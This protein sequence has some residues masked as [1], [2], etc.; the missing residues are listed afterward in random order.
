MSDVPL[1]ALKAFKV[2][3]GDIGFSDTKGE[4]STV[5]EIVVEGV[6]AVCAL[7]FYLNILSAAAEEAVAGAGNLHLLTTV[8]VNSLGGDVK[9]DDI[10]EVNGNIVC[11]ASGFHV[12]NVFLVAHEQVVAV[13]GRAVLKDGGVPSAEVYSEALSVLGALRRGV[14][15]KVSP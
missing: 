9:D 14:C 5:G 2:S 13:L 8:A 1:Y 11:C 10:L 6:T 12:V 15:L 4:G 3:D 7:P